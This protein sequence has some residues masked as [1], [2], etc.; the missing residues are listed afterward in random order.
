MVAMA[1]A[2]PDAQTDVLNNRGYIKRNTN[3]QAD[4]L[5]KRRLIKRDVIPKDEICADD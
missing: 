5:S 1:S 2:L 4:L 3:V